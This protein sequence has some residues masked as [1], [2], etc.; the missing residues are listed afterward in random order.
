MLEVLCNFC[1]WF[2]GDYYLRLLLEEDEKEEEEVTAMKKSLVFY[3]L[4][5][6]SYKAVIK[7]IYLHLRIMNCTLIKESKSYL[8]L[9][10]VRTLARPNQVHP[11]SARYLKFHLEMEW[12][13][14][15]QLL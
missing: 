12:V 10:I 9:Q 1:W 15:W 6:C 3:I 8:G 4:Q 13:D 2:A 14:L 5:L 7:S 11:L